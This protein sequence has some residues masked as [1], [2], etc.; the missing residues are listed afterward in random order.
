EL[1]SRADRWA[2]HDRLRG[3]WGG[4]FHAVANRVLRRHGRSVGIQP[5]FTLLD[6]ADAADLLAL[7]RDERA[8]AAAPS[9]RRARKEVLVSALSRVVNTRTPLDV[10]LRTHYPWCADQLDELRPVYAEYVARKRAR[11]L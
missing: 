1:L 10:V 9:R 8:E 11:H 4:T 2:G 3:A 5:D 7:V 6:P